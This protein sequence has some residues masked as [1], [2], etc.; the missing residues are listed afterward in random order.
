[1]QQYENIDQYIGNLKKGLEANEECG[2]TWYNLGVA[3]L[4]KREFMEAERAFREAV[5]CSPKLAEG[6]VQ[7]GGI[8]LQRGDLE[9]CLNFN[10]QASKI[11][12]FFAAPWGNI[13]FCYLQQGEV[14]KSI[15]AL[16]RALK[17]D[18]N[19][20]QALATIGSAYYQEGDLESA[21][22]SLKKSLALQPK[23]GP[24]WN[25]LALIRMEQGKYAEARECLEKAKESGYDVPEELAREVEAKL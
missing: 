9:G 14:D 15:K 21:E 19:F 20:L 18:P 23:F 4:A 22:E 5:S 13:G 2:N 10:L 1:M 7:L 17:Y 6:Y 8:A 3:L 12:P 16:K 25:N 24:A 11:R